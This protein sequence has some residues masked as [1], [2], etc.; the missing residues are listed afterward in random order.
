MRKPDYELV[1]TAQAERLFSGLGMDDLQEK[2][3]ESAEVVVLLPFY[4]AL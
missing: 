2:H 3:R 4:V 1:M